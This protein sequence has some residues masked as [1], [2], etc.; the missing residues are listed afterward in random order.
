[1]DLDLIMLKD[2][3]KEA[4]ELEKAYFLPKGKSK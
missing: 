4:I 1:M 3:Y 2:Y